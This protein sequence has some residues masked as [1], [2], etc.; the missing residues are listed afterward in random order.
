ML[1]VLFAATMSLFEGAQGDPPRHAV[2]PTGERR[3]PPD[4]PRLSGEDQER[5]L[6]RIF[7]E[8]AIVRSFGP[9]VIGLSQAKMKWKQG[10]SPRN[11]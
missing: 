5:G 6:K 2:K 8:M 11:S 7:R 9:T 3:S 1:K 4:V 10:T